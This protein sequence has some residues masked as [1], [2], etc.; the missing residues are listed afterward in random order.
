MYD[1]VVWYRVVSAKVAKPARFMIDSHSCPH[2]Y[3][4]NIVVEPLTILRPGIK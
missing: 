2:T 3:I 1:L 4:T